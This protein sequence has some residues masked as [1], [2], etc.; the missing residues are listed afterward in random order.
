MKAILAAPWVYDL[1][2]YIIRGTRYAPRFVRE[3]VR[4][5]P[6]DRVLDIGCGTGVM[7]H[8]MPDVKYVGFDMSRPYI[9]ACRQRFGGRGEFHCQ[10]LTADT[11]ADY[12]EFDIVLAIGV[13]H[14]LDDAQASNMFSLARSALVPGGR[15]L[16]LDGVYTDDQSAFVKRMLRNDRGEYVRTEPV[17][18]ELA[19]PIFGSVATSVHHDL[20]RIPYTVLIMECTK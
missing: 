13:V 18:K 5:R 3:C 16:T 11:V 9:D 15:L 4:P 12:G 8:Y 2:Q 7:L 17:Y 6:G 1:A 10:L 20:F 19:T 14:H